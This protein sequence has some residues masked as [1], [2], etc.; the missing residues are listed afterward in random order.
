M[1]SDEAKEAL[2]ERMN[3]QEFSKTLY[4]PEVI[5]IEDDNGD[6]PNDQ[7]DDHIT[8]DEIDSSKTVGEEIAHLMVNGKE[9]KASEEDE[10]CVGTNLSQFI[11][12]V[13]SIPDATT[14]WMKW[15][16]KKSLM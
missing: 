4:E 3:N 7:G 16:A 5:E 10:V 12:H 13:F 1:T 14:A 15:D 2:A 9:D 8:Y 6:L 11:G